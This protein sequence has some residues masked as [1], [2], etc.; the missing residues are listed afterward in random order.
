[1]EKA[2]IEYEVVQLRLPK[3]VMDLLR[4]FRKDVEDYLATVIVQN[5]SSVLEAD[6]RHS[7]HGEII[8]YW[9]IVEKFNLKTIFEVYDA[10][11]YMPIRKE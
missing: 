4:I 10:T 7:V 2:E 5:V 6:L 8:D 3:A 9:R 1:M 11:V